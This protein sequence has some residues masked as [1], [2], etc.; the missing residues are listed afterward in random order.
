MVFSIL[1]DTMDHSHR[2]N[3][4]N[5]RGQVKIIKLR[6]KTESSSVGMAKGNAA[7]DLAQRIKEVVARFDVTLVQIED[8]VVLQRSTFDIMVGGEPYTALHLYFNIKTRAFITRTWG[9]THSKGHIGDLSEVDEI[10]RQSFAEGGLMCCPGHREESVVCGHD[11]L[12]TVEYPFKRMV[13]LDCVVLHTKHGYQGPVEMCTKCITS[14][15]SQETCD[16]NVAE[17]IGEPDIVEV[18]VEAKI[19]E[20]ITVADDETK[21]PV[22]DGGKVTEDQKGGT[23]I[24]SRED[25]MIEEPMQDGPVYEQV[26]DDQVEESLEDDILEY[27]KS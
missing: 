4:S 11:N 14:L 16:K 24:E 21:H 27:L 17:D 19:H 13:A 6:P 2:L 10:C 25:G 12:L 7:E 1:T 3:H 23:I 8:W 15:R 18:E 22:L 20:V 9:R 26:E 5:N